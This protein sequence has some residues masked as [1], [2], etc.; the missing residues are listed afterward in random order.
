MPRNNCSVSLSDNLE[1]MGGDIDL[2]IIII[3][4]PLSTEP[5]GAVLF[6]NELVLFCD[7]LN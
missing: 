6:G 7:K 2:C 3:H 1:N 5:V 4:F